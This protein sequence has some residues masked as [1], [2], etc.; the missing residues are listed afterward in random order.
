VPE[1]SVVVPVY[2]PGEYL[3]RCVASLVDQTASTAGYEVIFVDDGSTDGSGAFLDSVAASRPHLRVIHQQNSQW[4]GRPRNVGLAAARGQYVFF[5]D[6]DDWLATNAVERLYGHAVEWNSDIVIPKM[7]GLGRRVPHQLFARTRPQVS[8]AT[9]PLMDSLSPQK[10]FRRAFLDEHQIR[11]PEGKRRLEDHHFVVSAYLQAKVVSVAADQTYYYLVRR[12]DGGNIS[13]GAVDW[14]NYFDSLAE[15]VQVLERHTDPGPARDRLLRRWLQSEMCGRLSGRQYL[16]RSSE[17]A[18]ELF[19]HAHR[20]ARD[21][22][23]PG[24]VALLPPL[25][26]PVGQAIIDGDSGAVRGHAEALAAWSVQ[27]EI[28]DLGWTDSGL[29]LSGTV[30]LTDGQADSSPAAVVQRFAELLPTM[31]SAAL[32]AALKSTRVGLE[33][34]SDTTGERWPLPLAPRFSEVLTADFAG[35][36]DCEHAA[37][38]QPLADGIWGIAASVRGLGFADWQRLRIVGGQLK[39]GPLLTNQPDVRPLAVLAG[40]QGRLKL[41]IG[42]VWTAPERSWT[43]RIARRLPP[44]VKRVLRPVW[45][46]VR[47]WT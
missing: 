21:H 27:A 45:R 18:Q 6:A 39:G 13:T 14:K 12:K 41:R 1:V 15:A 29:Q 3:R 23:G 42:Q 26:Q 30:S 34:V 7:A 38:G 43:I 33:L 16:N 2:N 4:P 37:N 24:V 46:R 44:P 17:D 25:L 22:F 47:R 19:D 10:L 31:S 11:F 28:L 35:D 36:I 20:V 8:L 32:Q 5:C 40:N 9:A